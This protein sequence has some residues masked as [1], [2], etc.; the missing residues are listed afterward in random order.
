MQRIVLSIVVALCL[1]ATVVAEVP[2]TIS[3]QGRLTDNGVP[4]SGFRTVA[5]TI[6]S[7]FGVPIWNSGVS[8]ILFSE[9]LFSVE[10]GRSPQPPLPQTEWAA[11]TAM[12]LGVTFPPDPEL[13]PRLGF[14]TVPY[15]LHALTSDSAKSGGGWF[16]N[17]P[18]SQLADPAGVVAI[19]L[20][21]PDA[22]A[23]IAPV[24]DQIGLQISSE[25]NNYN[26]PALD[27]SSKNVVGSIF[28]RGLSGSLPVIP[29][30]AIF[31]VSNAEDGSGVWLKSYSS[32]YAGLLVENDYA[33][34]AIITWNPQGYGLD[35]WYGRGIRSVVDS[36]TAMKAE[37]YCD[38][39]LATVLSS[40]YTGS[41]VTDH[42]A[43]AGYSR[44]ADWYGF[45]G[46]F[47]GGYVG[48]D[49][50][51]NATGTHAYYGMRG[52]VDGGTGLSCMKYG[53]LGVATGSGLN[54]GVY[55]KAS[56]GANN[57]AG[58]FEGDVIVTGNISKSA[59]TLAIDNPA[60]PDNS[61]LQQADLVSDKLS[62]VYSGNVTLDGS[63]STTVQLP[64]WL[65]SFCGDF[66]YQLTCI[67]GYAPVYVSSKIA[68]SKFSIAGGTPGLEISWQVTG[69]RKDGYAKA[70]PLLVERSKTVAEQG[71]YLHPEALGYGPEMGLSIRPELDVSMKAKDDAV[72]AA[73][74]ALARPSI[75]PQRPVTTEKK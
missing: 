39:R 61:I 62:A 2:R 54:Y 1:A 59:S 31:V 12:T 49:G 43:V 36:A 68:D 32:T 34:G 13:I 47:E 55:G 24:G 40:A 63:G 20:Y 46:V 8:Q 75:P 53:V 10:L 18:V 45:G 58:Y 14:R 3:Y 56:G 7:E 60:D 51:V 5:F 71:K 4:I 11:D 9:G 73:T 33:G 26:Y 23:A 50:K 27:L 66:R 29:Q 21:D 25:S 35:S 41:L 52:Y 67:G 37:S 64:D 48:V 38:D 30:P 70:H 28:R 17:G 6:Y 15:A 19:G 74:S 42:I 72:R 57:Y 69:I 65:E 44:P 16:H 22:K